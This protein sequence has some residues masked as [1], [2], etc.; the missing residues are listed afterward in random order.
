MKARPAALILLNAVL[1]ERQILGQVDL[2][3]E[4]AEAA[5]ANRLALTVLRNLGAVDAVIKPYTT[6]KPQIGVHNLLR[7]GTVELLVNGQDA[8][9]V[10]S[11]IVG[12]AKTQPH[13]RK[14]SG[15]VNAILRKI[16]VEGAEA[17]AKAPPQRLPPW[18]DKALRKRIGA[19]GIKAIELAQSKAPPIDL[20]PRDADFTLEGADVLPTGSLRLRNHPQISALPGFAEGKFWVQDAAAALPVKLLGDVRGKR[21]LDL[22]AAPGGKTM[23]LAAAG[24][25][26]TALDISG[27]RLRRVSENLAR[28]GLTAT[29]VTGD[30]FQ[31]TGPEDVGPYDAILLDAPCS[32]TGTIRRHPDLPFVKDG[33]EVEPLTKLQMQLI[34]HALTL[35]KPG[36]TLVYCT[37]SLL[38]VEGEFQVTAALK[39][40]DG[41]SVIATDPTA[42]GGDTDWASPE[43]GLRLWPSTWADVGGMDGF[44]MAALR[45]A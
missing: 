28:T 12:I 34:D 32:A 35:L 16:A 6:R 41:L 7:L 31:H 19:E 5:R 30:A 11:D 40:H 33:S 4:G 39:R 45:R 15:M 3:A 23:Q 26:V 1:R 36:G 20:T 17:F 8:H 22:C 43:G 37:C 25:D 42:L 21:V 2:P 18:L 38:P 14:A 27:P 10:V 13:T 44:Y 24:A 29:L 9:G